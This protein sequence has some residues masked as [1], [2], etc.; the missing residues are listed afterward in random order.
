MRRRRFIEAAAP[1]SAHHLR[2]EPIRKNISMP[3]RRRLCLAL[4]PLQ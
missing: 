1:A 3:R 2:R 4:Q